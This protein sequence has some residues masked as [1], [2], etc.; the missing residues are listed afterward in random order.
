MTCQ[1]CG[2]P[3]QERF[4]PH[5]GEKR[6][7]PHSLTVRHYAEETLE[8]FTHFDHRFFRSV[9]ALLLKPGLLTAEFVR[10]RRVPYMLPLPLF[11]VC[12]LLFFFFQ[13]NNVF[14]QPLSSFVQYRPYTYFNTVATVRRALAATG[15]PEQDFATRFNA[16]M[17]SASKSYLF[18][19]IPVFALLL[20]LLFA[21]KRRTYIEHLIFSTHLYSFLLLFFLLQGLFILLPAQI[22]LQ[23]RWTHRLLEATFAFS[24]LLAL[25]VY[26]TVGFR[27]FYGVTRAWSVGAALLACV[28]FVGL[29]V[30]YRMLLFYKIV[31]FG[32]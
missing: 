19:Q 1:T 31:A 20:A 15:Q 25:V 11:L 18:V 10:G 16:A 2:N 30:G 5:C 29:V 9:R 23:S 8:G 3:H 27:R 12:N 24:S 14:N 21:P 26:L 17:T 13:T 22:L 6:H 32:H 4:C 28:A 7:D